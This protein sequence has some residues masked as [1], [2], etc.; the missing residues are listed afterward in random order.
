MQTQTQKQTQTQTQTQTQ[1][2]TRDSTVTVT[3]AGC[4]YNS[5]FN[6]MQ[7]KGSTHRKQESGHKTAFL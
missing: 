7:T 5:K 3:V 2:G 4:F 6:L 1:N